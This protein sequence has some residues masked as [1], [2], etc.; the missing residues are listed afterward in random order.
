M[1]LPVPILS[2]EINEKSCFYSVIV[3]FDNRHGSFTDLRE[4]KFRLLVVD[5]AEYFG[6]D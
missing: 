5:D 3:C 2:I 6:R 1:A 4:G